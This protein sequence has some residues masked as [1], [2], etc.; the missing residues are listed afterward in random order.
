VVPSPPH[1]RSLSKRGCGSG[2]IEGEGPSRPSQPSQGGRQKVST[3]RSRRGA[4]F[5]GSLPCQEE[6]GSLDDDVD[7]PPLDAPFVGSLSLHRANLTR[8][9]HEAQPQFSAKGVDI[10]QE[11]RFTNPTRTQTPRGS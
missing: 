4:S 11:I 8:G 5:V 10:L 2:G 7:L 6:D 1:R 3:S 9:S